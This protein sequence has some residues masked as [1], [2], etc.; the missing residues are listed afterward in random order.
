MGRQ[1]TKSGVEVDA[2]VLFDSLWMVEEER[3]G[4]E[5]MRGFESNRNIAIATK[6]P[7]FARHVGYNRNPIDQGHKSLSAAVADHQSRIAPI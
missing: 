2:I 7:K 5:R 1:H 3:E 6:V 4:E